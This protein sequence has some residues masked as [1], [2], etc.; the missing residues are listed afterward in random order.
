MCKGGLIR[1][2]DF[3]KE[4]AGSAEELDEA[5]LAVGVVAML[6]EGAFVEELEAEGT[7]EVFWMP[8]LPHGSHTFAYTRYIMTPIKANP[9]LA[10]LQL[11]P[12]PYL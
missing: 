8:L 5:W 7:S 1:L 12:T 9:K 4:A 3:E 2:Q 11:K 6:L 10:L